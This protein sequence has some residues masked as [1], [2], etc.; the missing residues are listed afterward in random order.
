MYAINENLI[1]FFNFNLKGLLDFLNSL[2][3]KLI[4]KLN[5][6]FTITKVIAILIVVFSGFWSFYRSSNKT[7]DVV[8]NWFPKSTPNFSKAVLAI[9]SSLF[10]FSG[11]LVNKNLLL[12]TLLIF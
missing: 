1:F 6:L 4:S 5:N 9:Y 3:A 8:R 7:K 10:S 11:W 12:S 2:N